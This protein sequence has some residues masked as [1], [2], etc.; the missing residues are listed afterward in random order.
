MLELLYVQ[1]FLIF[2]TSSLQLSQ[3]WEYH[4]WWQILTFIQ[5]LEDS[6]KLQNLIRFYR[7]TFQALHLHVYF[8]LVCIDNVQHTCR[9]KSQ[10]FNL[11]YSF[12]KTIDFYSLLSTRLLGFRF[13]CSNAVSLFLGRDLQKVLSNGLLQFL[14]AQFTPCKQTLSKYPQRS[15]VTGKCCLCEIPAWTKIYTGC[16]R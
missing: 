4:R 3:I 14:A 5:D 7:F 11:Q 6:P 15:D 8:S 16:D 2:I 1:N 13:T 12:I 9:C 10:V